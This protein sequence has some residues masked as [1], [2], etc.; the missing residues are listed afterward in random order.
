[1]CSRINDIG[2]G[3]VGNAQQVHSEGGGGGK[4]DVM[5]GRGGME[6]LAL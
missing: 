6:S 2:C 1:M 5:G 4:Q 3:P